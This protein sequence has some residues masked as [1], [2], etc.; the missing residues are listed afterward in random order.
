MQT[1][2]PLPRKVAI[3]HDWLPVYGGA[4]R[5]LEQI[6]A[7]FPEADLFSMVDLLPP[8]QRHFLGGRP[9]TTSFLQNLPL[10]MRQRYRAF[11]PL[12][13]TAVE[14]FDLSRYELVISSS[15][16]VA[17]GVLTGPDQLHVSYCHSPMR[18][19]WDLQHQYLRESKLESSGKGLLARTFLHYLRLWDAASEKRV[20]HFLTNSNFVRK[21]IKKVYRRDA[22]VV[23][24]PVDTAQFTC[25]EEKE[26]Y[27]VT[28]S[29]LVP[30]KMV[31]LIVEAFA[32][33]P[34]RELHVVGDGP[35]YQRLCRLATPNVK[36]LGHSS[37]EEMQREMRGAKAFVFAAE[38][39][40]G[41]VLV[42]A[43]A[44]GT[45][46]VAYGK[47]GA[48]ESVVPGLT[49]LFFEEQTTDAIRASVDELVASYSKFS[50]QAIREHAE[51][52]SSDRFRAQFASEVGRRWNQ[53]CDD[54][55]KTSEE[56]FPREI[57][58]NA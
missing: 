40:F 28:A 16:A 24:P 54:Q 49:G 21:R 8:E 36:M 33:M 10:W 39:D 56:N 14:Q 34:E 3:V 51:R 50:P 12:M 37:R 5:V 45:P 38:E 32:R 23:Y 22:T 7:V 46:V 4:E 57:R 2:H 1:K 17:K 29:R 13:P 31:G 41:I 58:E 48:L 47:G 55:G 27:F 42:E 6:I 35:E 15:Y 18:Y 44:C 43:Q 11:L 19:A 53:F 52:F 30:Y 20:D 9:V 26:E 25:C